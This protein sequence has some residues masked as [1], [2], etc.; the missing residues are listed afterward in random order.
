MI[1]LAT[2]PS[3]PPTMSQMMKF[4]SATSD[5]ADAGGAA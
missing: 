2:Q 5:P 1:M 3:N 4:I